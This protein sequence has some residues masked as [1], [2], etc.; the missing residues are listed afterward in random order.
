MVLTTIPLDPLLDLFTYRGQ[1][2]ERFVYQ[3]INGVT[4][5]PLGWIT[6]EK[7]QSPTLSHSTTQAIKRRLSLSLGVSDTTEINPITD[8]ILPFMIVGGVTWPLGRY[9]FTDETDF[10]TTGGGRGTFTLLDEGFII[11]QP[12]DTA[13]TAPQSE[14]SASISISIAVT[15]GV[16]ALLDT[17]VYPI[18]GR[19]V[20]YTPF[21][22]IGS[23][24][25]GQ[26]RGQILD[27]YATQGDYFPY[28]MDNTSKFRMIRTKDPGTSIPDFDFDAGNKIKRDSISLTSDVLTAPNRF[29]VISNSGTALNE[30]IVGS[31][32]I[33]PSAPHSIANRGFVIP[34]TENLQVDTVMQANA[35]AR[36]IGIRNTVYERVSLRTALDPRH[37]SFNIVRFNGDNWLEL[38]WSMELTPGGDMEHTMR[39]AYV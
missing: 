14:F 5:A 7:G 31:Y 20:E 36:N 28:W 1:R 29:V 23:W 35:A 4:N 10:L 39:K 11:D 33:P 19:D 27:A 12:L 24:S 26:T 34:R 9:M 16:L 8:R 38:G 3:L 6:P 17:V 18:V 22:A 2:T 15:V 30:A 21:P 25:A 32:D 37:D 13:F